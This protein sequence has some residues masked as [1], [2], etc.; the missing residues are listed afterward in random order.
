LRQWFGYDG[1]ALVTRTLDATPWPAIEPV[2]LEARR[3]T[4]VV[5]HGLL[6]HASAPNRSTRP[7]HAYSLHLI[8]GRAI[9]AA[10]NWL[11]RPGLPLR[12]FTDPKAELHC[13]LEGLDPAGTG[14]RARGAQ[15]RDAS[16]RHVRRQGSLRL[17]G[18]LSASSTPTIG[19]GALKVT[20]FRRR[21]L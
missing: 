7:R 14:A 9:Y 18:F 12:G 5:L 17:A 11:Q 20:R 2:A 6:P 15:W 1:S 19:C 16:R 13:H 3:G 8:D 4:L 21:P 10:D